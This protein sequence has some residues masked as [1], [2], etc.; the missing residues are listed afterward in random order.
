MVTN[1]FMSYFHANLLQKTEIKNCQI[2]GTLTVSGEKYVT[3]VKINMKTV[4]IYVT[5]LTF[6]NDQKFTREIT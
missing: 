6:R 1:L 5:I 3:H 2:I 4:L